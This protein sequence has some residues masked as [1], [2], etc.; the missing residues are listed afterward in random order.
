MTRIAILGYGYWGSKHVRVFSA[1]PGVAVTIVDG[2]PERRAAAA[3]DYPMAQVRE[4]LDEILGEIDGV[5]IATP[6]GSHAALALRALD[7]GV[8]VLVEKP[9]ATSTSDALEMIATAERTGAVLMAGH[10]F[11]YNAA[12]WRLRDLID[13]GTLG[14]IYYLDSARLNLGL[15]QPDVNVLWD[16]A[17]HDVSIANYLLRSEPYEVSAWGHAHAGRA[18]VDVAHVQ[19]Q[20]RSPDVSAYIHVSWLDPAKVRRVTVAGSAKMAVYDD[21]SNDERIRIH[22]KGLG[23]SEGVAPSFPVTYRSGDIISPHVAFDEPLAVEDRHFVE[24]VRDLAECRTPGRTGLSVVRVLEAADRSLIEG[25]TIRLEEPVLE[26][27][28]S[29]AVV[30]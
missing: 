25:R 7:A 27:A 29:A 30:S 6:A 5:V 16:L 18:V 26:R 2:R 4:S 14:D 3:A 9:L 1:M 13:N 15:Y 17:P 19:V 22:D 12:V 24:C 10:T 21:T 28:L 23:L 20:Y 8:D 11:E